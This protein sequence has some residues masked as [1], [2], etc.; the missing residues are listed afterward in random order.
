MSGANIASHLHTCLGRGRRNLCLGG[1]LGL[2]L[3]LGQPL[4]GRDLRLAV[5][6]EQLLVLGHDFRVD[7]LEDLGLCVGQLGLGGG[8]RRNVVRVLCRE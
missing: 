8:G 5:R 3:H 4:L 6:N 2:H 1:L 7:L